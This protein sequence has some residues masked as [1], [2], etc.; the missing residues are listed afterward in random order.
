MIEHVQMKESELHIPGALKM[1]STQES[2]TKWD[3]VEG[4][5]VHTDAQDSERIPWRVQ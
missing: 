4:K 5:R 1:L 3:M 2:E